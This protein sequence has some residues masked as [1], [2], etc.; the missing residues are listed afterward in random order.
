ML[1]ELD[2]R[3]SENGNIAVGLFFETE[4]GET[5]ISLKD[6]SGKLQ[7]MFPVAGEDAFDAFNHPFVYLY[8]DRNVPS[9]V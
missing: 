4:T 2:Y 9:F 8:A 3:V 6:R 7:A 5:V 1:R